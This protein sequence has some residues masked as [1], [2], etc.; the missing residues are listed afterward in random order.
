[1]TN[2]G[3][4]STL[5]IDEMK[6]EVSIDEE[7]RSRLQTLTGAWKRREGETG[8]SLWKSFLKQAFSYLEFVPANSGETPLLYPLYEDFG[9]KDVVSV[10]GVVPESEELDSVEIGR[11][12]PAKLIRSL[13]DKELDWGILTNGRLWRLYSRSSSRPFEDYVEH[14]LGWT[15][16]KQEEAE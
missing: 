11:F 6:A 3:M 1:M 10:V 7:G 14:D 4:F 15:K 13:E 5:F 9:F 2:S 8:D 16:E 12:Y